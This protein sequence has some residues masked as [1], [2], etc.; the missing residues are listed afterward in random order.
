M[1]VPC[2]CWLAAVSWPPCARARSAA[3]D[4]PMPLPEV[5]A[6]CRPRQNRSKT[7]GSSSAGMPGAGVGDLEHRVRV[8]LPGADGD[9]AA[10]RGEFQRVAEQ[11][12][13]HLVQP[14]RISQDRRRGQLPVHGDIRRVE[15]AGQAVGRGGGEVGQVAGL[16][17]QVQGGG[18]SGGQVLQVANHP[19]QPQHLIAQ[20]AE[21]GR[22][23][24]G[25][26]VQQRL[27][28]GLQHRDRG[29]Q[30]MGDSGDE[31]AAD[32]F[33]PVQRAAI[34]SNAAASSR[35]SA[36]AR[37]GPARAERSPAV[38]ARV[39]AISL[40]TGRV[41]RRAATRPVTSASRAASPAAPAMARSSAACSLRSA[42][43]RP[44]PVNRAA[45]SPIR[46]PRTITAAL[47]GGPGCAVKPGED[48][49]A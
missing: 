4:R 31:V 24:L 22:G 34:W 32:L 28:P 44:D 46:C 19:R 27:M 20:R 23:G 12:R 36:G 41:I 49:T 26:T 30:L 45:A 42:A 29:A 38:I 2:P 14:A 21:F 43:L 40:A 9:P 37:T 3:T 1:V 13:D 7:W 47:D 18:V 16:A 5:W 35:S 48:A 17:G 15:P 11:V 6:A 25:N 33:L 8:V 39:T 10:G